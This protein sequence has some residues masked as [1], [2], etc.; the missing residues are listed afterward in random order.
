MTNSH[1]NRP[2]QPRFFLVALLV[3]AT[4]AL[5]AR[6]D[7]TLPSLISDHA[8]LQK[9]AKTA[10]WG[11]A[12]PG[13]RVTASLAGVSGE[14]TAGADGKWRIA[15]DLSHVG[16][17]PFELTVKEKNLCVV[18]DVVVGEVWLASGQSNMSF[19]LESCMG[20]Q[21]AVA[22]SANPQLREFRVTTKASPIPI[23]S[24][25]G[26][27]VVA[28]PTTSGRFS[29]LGYY[30]AKTLQHELA[31]PI[32]VLNSSWA[33]TPIEPWTSLDALN[34]V[35]DLKL[36]AAKNRQ[37]IESYPVRR[38]SFVD[39][40]HAWES[41]FHRALPRPADI[42]SF[43][44]PNVPTT[45][46][47]K[48]CLPGRFAAVGLPDAGAVWFRRKMA[49]TRD[50]VAA[51][52]AIQFGAIPGFDAVYWNGVK[53]GET[54]LEKGGLVI[55]RFY[56]LRYNDLHLGPGEGVLAI[57]VAVPTDGGA[58]LGPLR[59]GN[60]SLD[61]EWLAKIE[62]ELPSLEAAAKSAAP[63]PLPGAPDPSK[64]A[65]YLYNGM[66]APLIPYT[67]QG[68]IW[69]QGEAN[70]GRAFQYRTAFPL[71][72]QDWRTRWGEGDF[73]FYFCQ[74]ANFRAKETEPRDSLWAELREAQTRTLALP[75]TGQAI[76]IDIGESGDIHP[77]NKKNAGERLA[78]V[79]LARTYA[80]T[81]PYSGPAYDSQTIE[82]DK[83]RLK[84]RETSGGL[85][86]KPL[87]KEY[88][89]SSLRKQTLP[90]V[91]NSPNSELE[92]FAICGQ[93]RK[94]VWADA[95]IDGLT[96]VVWS[97]AVPR[98]IAVRYG[99]AD[100][101]TVNLYNRAGFPAGPFRTDAFP[102][103]TDNVK[104]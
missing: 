65:A 92:G 103:T 55:P 10:L 31:E 102:G 86:A 95:R 23:A 18:H 71:M 84:F 75:N 35:P 67:I 37:Y 3:A 25:E 8:V 17:G 72:I 104:L 57:R 39:A 81:I 82:G 96:V 43:V 45:D 101:P 12:E 5:S 32:G 85:V 13:A 89:V 64:Y 76:L 11:T 20:A 26:K 41:K 56:G 24:V 97:T 50:V 58:I 90:L 94:W 47:K 79:A 38:Q 34:S 48:V 14:A 7:I 40:F 36:G 59:W 61:G 78:A 88:L 60:I 54:P 29:A 70:A 69:Y 100:N 73:P 52:A 6:A 33:G 21:E 22:N 4:M 30:F 15:I 66:I 68:A 98:P 1:R 93:D 87:A 49:L 42:S 62:K 46:W 99:W 77:R 9:S 44:D 19:F 74:L 91:R 63:A 16:P 28:G 27:W 2:S 51:R 80:R 53:L 83:I